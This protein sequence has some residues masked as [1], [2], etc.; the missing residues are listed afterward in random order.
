MNWTK[1]T[2]AQLRK[3]WAD[4]ISTRNIGIELGCSKNAV[5]GQAYRQ[6]LQRRNP[7]DEARKVTLGRRRP[8]GAG[9]R[10]ATPKLP[11]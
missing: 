1:K 3:L 11:R 9:R 5:I 4:G 10:P 7:R 6:K 2:I 8:E